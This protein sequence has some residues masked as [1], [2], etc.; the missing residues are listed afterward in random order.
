[1]TDIKYTK[2]FIRKYR[3]LIRKNP[4]LLR[5]FSKRIDLFQDNIAHP[6]LH[7]HKLSGTLRNTFSFSITRDIR[8][9]YYWE[10]SKA[11]FVDIGRHKEVYKA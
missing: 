3:K 4:K 10:K 6:S 9:I 5:K 7:S 2:S 1:M 11:I 8:V